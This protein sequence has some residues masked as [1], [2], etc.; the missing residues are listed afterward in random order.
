MKCKLC[1]RVIESTKKHCPTCARA[2]KAIRKVPKKQR[3]TLKRL[4]KSGKVSARRL[5]SV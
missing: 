4:I 3:S 2:I 5:L 1:N